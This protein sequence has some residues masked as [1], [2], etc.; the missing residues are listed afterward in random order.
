M[1]ADKMRKGA[2]AT[3]YRRPFDDRALAQQLKLAAQAVSGASSSSL[4][5]F[6]IGL[7]TNVVPSRDPPHRMP[8][9]CTTFPEVIATTGDPLSPAPTIAL[10]SSWQTSALRDPRTMTST[11]VAV[12]WT[13]LQPV[14][15]LTLVT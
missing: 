15:R 13:W 1:P 6:A 3:A 5:M 14:V 8:C 11:Q 10:T 9:S 7:Y 2:K 4:A 12:T